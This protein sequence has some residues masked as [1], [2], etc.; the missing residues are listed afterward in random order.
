[1]K[2]TT[3]IFTLALGIFIQ[4]AFAQTGEEIYKAQC[5]RCHTIGGG[6]LVGPDLKGAMKKYD[7]KWLLKWI[8]SSQTLINDGDKKAIELFEKYNEV[9]M[10]DNDYTD[11]QIKSVIAY[12]KEQSGD[13]PTATAATATAATASAP[14]ATTANV[15]TTKTETVQ[16]TNVSTASASPSTAVVAAAPTSNESNSS[17]NAVM[18]VMIAAAIVILI[19]ILVLARTVLILAKM[20]KEKSLKLVVQQAE[21]TKEAA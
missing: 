12:V 16:N 2:T 9:Q 17:S 20:L 6:Q 14:Q 4:T 15:A 18:I 11:D 10:A 1:M 21:Q 19:A 5:V 13:M 7:D 8:R 3:F